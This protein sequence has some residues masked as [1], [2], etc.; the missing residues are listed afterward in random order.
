MHHMVLNQS[1]T[2][3]SLH[4]MAYERRTYN[5]FE[6]QLS[7]CKSLDPCIF[8]I[9]RLFDKRKQLQGEGFGELEYTVAT[10]M[11]EHESLP[12]I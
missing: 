2:R 6:S 1:L 7:R 8:D 5:R 12:T 10:G 3:A 11:S 4:P 9:E